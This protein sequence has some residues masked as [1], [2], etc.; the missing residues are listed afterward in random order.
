LKGKIITI[1]SQKGGVGKTT[2]AFNL[3]YTLGKMGNSVL[4]IDG[5]PQ[6]GVSV[7]SNLRNKTKT[8]LI[9]LLKENENT[10][11][12][13]EISKD[14]S[15][16][17]LGIGRIMAED[18]T[19]LEEK[20]RSGDL[21]MVI[22]SYINQFDYII[23]DAPAGVGSIVAS[24]LAVSDKVIMVVNCKTYSLQTIP[25]F[26]R[27]MRNIKDKHNP[28]L[29]LEGVVINMFNQKDNLEQ[30]ILAQ[31]KQAFPQDSFFNTII[32]FN[33]YFEKAG[34]YSV[35][36]LLMPQG[37][38]ASKPFIELA[39]ELKERESISKTGEE[40]DKPLMGLF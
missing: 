7:A 12:T 18:V 23:I 5:D 22:R 34:Y 40:D 28:P 21:G 4:L 15:I 32:P 20:A 19:I 35:P 38:L 36:V 25:L 29:K 39:I 30:S 37:H 2:I 1:A 16:S 14:R 27:V 13:V 26:L 10:K 17:I 33:S 31:I 24:F 11:D 6:G 8:G 3:S 9:D